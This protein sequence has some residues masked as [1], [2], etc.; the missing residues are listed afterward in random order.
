MTDKTITLDER[1]GMAAQRATEIRREVAAVAAERK[2]LRDRQDMLEAQLLAGPAVDWH[3]ASEKAAYLLHLFTTTQ[4]AQD[5]RRQTL[6]AAV[7]ADFQRL[8]HQSD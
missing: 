7:L 1:R 4:E 8:S 2:A 5:P 6:I 3:E